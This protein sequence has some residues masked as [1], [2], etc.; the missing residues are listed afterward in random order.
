MALISIN[1]KTGSLDE[2][3]DIIV[4]IDLGT[5]NSLV[6]YMKDGVPVCVSGDN[7]KNTLVPSVLHFN[8]VDEGNPDA[9]GKGVALVG[10][11]A[12]TKLITDPQNTIYSVK[13]LMGKAYKDVQ[14]Q[15]NYFGYK[16]I[17]TQ[18]DDTLV[19]VRVGDKFYTPTE[20]SS[21]ILKELK[22]RVEKDLGKSVSKAVITVPAYFNDAQ[23]QATRDAGKLAGLDVLRIVN[24]PT[25][26]ALAYGLDR[27]AAE[28]IAVYDLGGGT[29]DISILQ[30]QDGIFEVLST[31]GDT[32]L[33]GDDLDRAIIDYWIKEN[34]IHNELIINDKTFGQD[35][36]LAAEKAKKAL[37]KDDFFE[38]RITQYTLRITRNTFE[39]LIL[40][41]VEKT[42]QCCKSALADAKLTAKD[43][44]S[45]VMVGGS[46]RV[47]LV[48]KTVSDFFG[49]E[50]FDD[51]NPDEVVALGA[52]IQADVLAGNQR[53]ILLIDITPLSLGIETVGGL[54]DTIIPR[55]SK[56]PSKAGREYT[57]SVDGQKNLKVAVFQGER[58]LV[59]HNR[60]LGEFILRGI[61]PMPA[62]LPKIEISFYLDADGIL[63]VKAKELRSNVEQE[64]TMKASYGLSDEEMAMM[65]IDS[66]QNA[67]S[68]LQ[69]RSLLEARNEAN[70]VLLAV[71]KFLKHND[72]ILSE[73]EKATTQTLA[74][75]L[76]TAVGGD[77][78]DAI[79]A[80]MD[81]LN[82]YT[83]PMAHRA[84]DVNIA[85]A[86][87]GK[88]I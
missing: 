70:N 28:T 65:L 50:V 74:K 15:E 13:R 36:R 27:K 5:T 68:D 53:D 10:D 18:D 44:Q 78:K 21:F 22:T 35:I 71:E 32:F 76:K 48:K 43:I 52:A 9:S 17:N 33:G 85:A 19:K 3:K 72:E 51:V 59:Q 73:E 8:T 62:G 46:T 4:G 12:K 81:D 6:A 40:P 79:N 69:M 84:M 47:P 80:A 67:S 45:V 26:A 56:I 14:G 23:R 1:L 20:L 63:R 58:D 2:E 87:K 83:E 77:N 86:M 31:N 75:T 60:K 25:A 11:E 49:K 41:L 64:V 57:T 55:N 88:K 16:I 30:L 34:N 24:E 61:P 82:T 38:I 39:S 54:M 37:S 66:I 7:G 42:I 29:F